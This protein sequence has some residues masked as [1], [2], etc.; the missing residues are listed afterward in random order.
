[1]TSHHSNATRSDHRVDESRHRGDPLAAGGRLG[2]PDP[3]APQPPAQRG[4]RS[5][6]GGAERRGPDVDR[7]P[8]PGAVGAGRR[9][10]QRRRAG[11]GGDDDAVARPGGRGVSPV[12]HHDRHAR[13][14][15]RS[16]R[17]SPVCS[18]RTWRSTPGA[19]PKPCCSTSSTRSTSTSWTSRC[20][21]TIGPVGWPRR[22]SPTPADDRTLVAWG[23][24][25]GASDRTLQRTFLAGTGIGF[26]EWRARARIG[27]ALQLLLT[28]RPIAAIAGDVGFATTSAFGAAFRRIMGVAPVRPTD[29]GAAEPGLIRWSTSVRP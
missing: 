29:A 1:M 7:A 28:D 5:R 25:V 21:P 12:A 13:R 8:R 10:S 6:A 14:P 17:W 16:S 26:H 19:A 20:P 27:A 23:R 3:P 15:A 4:H 22:S 18:N 9:R 11:S 2:L 24:A